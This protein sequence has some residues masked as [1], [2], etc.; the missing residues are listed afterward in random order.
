MDFWDRVALHESRGVSLAVALRAARIMEARPPSVRWDEAL[1]RRNRIGEFIPMDG[2]GH[3]IETRSFVGSRLPAMT[4]KQVYKMLVKA[5]FK[6]IG[7]KGSHAVFEPPGGGRKVVVPMHG[8]RSIP[9]GTLMSILG[10][11]SLGVA[12][13]AA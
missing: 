13:A 9:R 10:V 7:Q 11:A 4:P 5:G 3:P 1:H 8:N 6:R 12:A 2:Q